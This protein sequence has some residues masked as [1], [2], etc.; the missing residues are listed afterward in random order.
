MIAEKISEK[1]GKK[2]IPGRYVH[3]ANSFHIYGSYFKDFKNFLETVK[4]RKWEDRVW[5]TEFAEP[6]FEIG[7]EKIRVEQSQNI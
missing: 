4:N 7:K 2:V 5:N 1:S 6:F 3:Y